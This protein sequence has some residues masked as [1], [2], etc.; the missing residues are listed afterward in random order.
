MRWLP[1]SSLAPVVVGY[2]V[3]LRSSQ[4]HPGRRIGPVACVQVIHYAPLVFGIQCRRVCLVGEKYCTRGTGRVY[5]T[6]VCARSPVGLA[7]GSSL[8]L[9]VG[10]RPS[11]IL[12]GL[13]P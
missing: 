9:P 8:P 4:V 2:M 11:G 7:R 13:N 3:E 12:S 6:K 1:T 10:P 5:C